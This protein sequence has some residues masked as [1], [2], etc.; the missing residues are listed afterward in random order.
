M[1]KVYNRE[2][3]VKPSG[4]IKGASNELG[5]FFLC[6]GAEVVNDVNEGVNEE[7]KSSFTANSLL[8]NELHLL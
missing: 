2:G 3:D 6:E 7:N 8:D 1:E 4:L 5:A